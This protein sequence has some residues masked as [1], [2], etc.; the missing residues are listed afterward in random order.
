MRMRRILGQR[1]VIRKWI[2]LKEEGTLILWIQRK[3][4]ALYPNPSA[5]I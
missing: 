4:H 2:L 1:G 5:L 3:K